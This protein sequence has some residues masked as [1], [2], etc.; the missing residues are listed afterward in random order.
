M[1]TVARMTSRHRVLPAFVSAALAGA[2][3]IAAPGSAFADSFSVT[4][5]A[6]SGAGTLRQAILATNANVGPDSITLD[7]PAGSTI[8]LSSDLPS[9]NERVDVVATAAGITVDGANTA[10]GFVA[11][12][13]GLEGFTMRR[14]VAAGV[15]QSGAAVSA[16]GNVTLADMTFTENSVSTHG[17]AVSVIGSGIPMT[18]TTLTITDSRFED[19]VAGMNGGAVAFN[20]QNEPGNTL[21]IEGSTFADNA[22]SADGGAISLTNGG[23]ARVATSRLANNTGSQDG[24]AVHGRD[25]NIVLD[26]VTLTDNDS[27]DGGGVAM[28]YTSGSPFADP[29]VLTITGSTID[30]NVASGMGGAV[31]SVEATVRVD[32]S[33]VRGNKAL[34]GGALFLDD[35]FL[36]SDRSTYSANTATA[37]GGVAFLSDSGAGSVASSATFTNVTANANSAAD[38]GAIRSETRGSTTIRHSTF[39]DNTASGR[40]GAIDANGPLAI[41][42]SI[43]FGNTTTSTNAPEI[44]GTVGSLNWSFLGNTSGATI[45]T[46]ADNQIGVN[47]QLEA[48]ADNGGPTRTRRLSPTSPAVNAGDPGFSGAPATDQRGGARVSSGRVDVGALELNGGA[49]SVTASATTVDE[50]GS[51]TFTVSRT[52]GSDGAAT[53][54]LASTGTA[55]NGVD[56]SDIGST[57]S[58]ADGDGT[59]RSVTVAITQDIA[60]DVD[61]TIVATLSAI[62][63]AVPGAP[64]TATVTIDNVPTPF[65]IPVAPARLADT[66]LNGETIDGLVQRI[67]RL[68]AGQT[69]EVDIAGRGGV[70][71]GV[72]AAVINITSAQPLAAGFFT[73]FPC[74]QDRP[75]TSVLNYVPGQNLA[76]E[77]IA[78][79]SDAGLVCV[80]AS[81]SSHLIVDVVGYVPT[82]SPYR[83]TSPSRMLDT[84][85]GSETVDGDFSGDGFVAA[86]SQFELQITGRIGIPQGAAAAVVNITAINPNAGG[87]ITVHPCVDPVPNASSLNHVVGINRANEIIAKL[88]STGTICIDNSAGLDL[89]VDLVGWLPAAASFTPTDP[90]RF[91]DTRPGANTQDGRLEGF[92]ALS[93]GQTLRVKIAGR[94]DV[95]DLATAAVVNIAAVNPTALGFFTVWNCDGAQPN[96]SSL[97]FVAGSNGSSEIVAGLNTSGEICVFT[98]AGTQLLVDVV[99]FAS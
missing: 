3:V 29:N 43:V 74:D 67:D 21:T 90:A 30:G 34:S 99:G 94:G 63:G 14:F 49:I 97:N 15:N 53:A 23:S 98:S 79:L 19:N 86:G 77:I 51:V 59:D 58:W 17:G 39:S 16:S 71:D 28:E 45:A 69:L 73:V 64:S 78:P 72:P 4:S 31:H 55:T 42:H 95:P 46:G 70:P 35:T 65:V 40:G 56:H 6:D 18:I 7:L 57:F 80:F 2:C 91:V 50:G 83:A 9:P 81:A 11:P 75:T 27:G 12:T 82:N 89:A 47:P 24:G 13:I 32:D 84:R 88:S 26:D 61:E 96:A 10:R 52:G 33:T 41:E 44:D 76:N 48:L 36:T 92:G 93:A 85:E 5:T 1:H 68:A 38:G 8:T 54:T 20:G 66:R 60:D 22:A 62:T 25:A 87:F 37:L